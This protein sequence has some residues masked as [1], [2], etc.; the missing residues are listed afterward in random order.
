MNLALGGVWVEG[1]S[2]ALISDAGSPK[3]TWYNLTA[4]VSYHFQGS[5]YCVISYHPA[6][7][8]SD[9]CPA[10]VSRTRIGVFRKG[11]GD[12]DKQPLSSKDLLT[13]LSRLSTAYPLGDHG[14]ETSPARRA[15]DWQR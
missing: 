3:A 11:L 2:T 10:N 13:G 4:G 8:N 5:C 15:R 7:Y 14:D 9:V 1:C 12:I 6:V